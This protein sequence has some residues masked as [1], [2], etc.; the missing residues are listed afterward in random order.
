MK[1][2]NELDII[3]WFIGALVK[4]LSIVDGQLAGVSTKK[5]SQSY[6]PAYTI[7]MAI[8]RYYMFHNYC[9]TNFSNGLS[10]L[11]V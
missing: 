5:E 2:R 1:K 8:L 7:M 10:H 4:S 3:Y 9:L 6:I 11:C